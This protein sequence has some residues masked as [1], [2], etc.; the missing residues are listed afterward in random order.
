MKKPKEEFDLTVLKLQEQTT[1]KLEKDNF[2]Q[3]GRRGCVRI[4]DVP[5]E[6]EET[7]DSVCEKVGE[8]LREACPYV[9]VSCSDRAYCI[10]SENKSCRNKTKCCSIIVCFIGFRHRT[11]FY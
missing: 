9:P 7:A 2:K 3:Y 5:V 4:D 6:S 11:L 1:P 10:G 8:F